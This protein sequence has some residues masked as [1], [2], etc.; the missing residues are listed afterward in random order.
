MKRLTT[1]HARYEYDPQQIL[2]LIGHVNYSLI[3][4][5]TNEVIL[6]CGTL[7]QFAR[8]WPHFL[9]VHKTALINPAYLRA[10]KPATKATLPSYITMQD[11]TRLKIARRRLPTVQQ[12]LAQL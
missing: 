3:Y 7:K 9:R 4:M 12:M 1:K 10:F 11:D 8:K 2:Y 6:V 5:T